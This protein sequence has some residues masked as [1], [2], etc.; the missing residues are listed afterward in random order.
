M[1]TTNPR[2]QVSVH[3]DHYEILSR[4]AKT[5]GRSRSSVVAELIGEF[6]PVLDKLGRTVEMAKSLDEEARRAWLDSTK[7]K[8]GP[9][10]RALEDTRDDALQTF[11]AMFLAIEESMHGARDGV[12][13]GPAVG[14]EA[15][16]TKA[17]PDCEPPSL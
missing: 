12:G 15:S 6:M 14:R 13:V 11:H 10:L 1:A 8:V 17:G 4:F 3:P 5:M 2:I 7:I 9:Q 16:D